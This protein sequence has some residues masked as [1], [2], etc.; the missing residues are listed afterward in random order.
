MQ[1]LD[2][3]EKDW[4]Q[5][6]AGIF[7]R[8]QR[9][10]IEI[11]TWARLVAL[12]S[13]LAWLVLLDRSGENPTGYA[14]I[15]ASGF[16]GLACW[17]VSRQ[18]WFHPW[19]LAVFVALDHVI[20]GVASIEPITIGGE[21]LPL[22]VNARSIWFAAYFLFI[23]GS[24]LTQRPVLVV[25]SGV[26]A[27]LSWSGVIL[28]ILQQPETFTMPLS[29]LW[30]PMAPEEW[31]RVA[32]H[33]RYVDI[34][35]W[36]TQ[37]LLLLLVA[38]TLAAAVKRW[39]G[40]VAS[41]AATEAERA[42]LARYFSPAM[43]ER[44]ASKDNPLSRPNTRVVSVLF[45]DLTGF[46]RLCENAPPEQIIELLRDFRIRME[47]AV[48]DHGGIVDKYIGDCVMATFGLLAPSGRDPAAALAC[49]CDMQQAIRDWNDDRANQGLAPVGLGI[50][51][52]YGAVVA[53]DIGGGGRLEFTVIGDTVN[54]ASRLMHLT[55]ELSAGIVISDEVAGAALST[56]GESALTGFTCVEAMSLRGRDGTVALWYRRD[57]IVDVV[58]AE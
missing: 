30:H 18:S 38:L 33:P 17:A 42:N 31:L 54:V 15:A 1:V 24:V 47:K 3:A 12:T 35:A 51:V 43:V 45:A 26:A 29:W 32:L 49:A 5:R 39:Q 36:L 20:I 52:H 37:V 40:V 22:A 25:W 57:E 7:L 53:G 11:A 8:E 4:S 21:T 50:G 19:M 34:T 13:L 46:T 14:V 48:F 27:A 2:Q 9:R 16:A 58:A 56:D 6:L 28:I 23:A 10:G 41:Q 55:R 44:L